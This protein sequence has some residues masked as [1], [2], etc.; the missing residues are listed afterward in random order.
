LGRWTPAFS[1]RLARIVGDGAL[2]ALANL[3]RLFVEAECARFGLAPGSEDLLLRPVDEAADRMC[4]S[5]GITNLPP[6]ALATA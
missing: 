5:C 6:G 4:D 2:G 1:R 3:T